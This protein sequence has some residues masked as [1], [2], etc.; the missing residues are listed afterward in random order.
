M[1]ADLDSSVSQEAIYQVN[2]HQSVNHTRVVSCQ[3]KEDSLI[4]ISEWKNEPVLVV[5][6][7]VPSSRH[8]PRDMSDIQVSYKLKV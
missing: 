6:T 7:V 5:P 2:F 8:I 1:T 4:G 3:R